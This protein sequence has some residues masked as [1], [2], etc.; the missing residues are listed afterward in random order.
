MGN[1]GQAP[2]H[3]ASLWWPDDHVWCVAS[4]VDLSWT[5]VGGPDA[6]VKAL[7]SDPKLEVLE[8]TPD[9]PVARIGSDAWIERWVRDAVDA[10]LHEEHAGISTPV[11]TVMAW[12][13]QPHSRKRAWLRT[14]RLSAW[15]H[16][17]SSSEVIN[18][19]DDASMRRLSFAVRWAI[20]ELVGD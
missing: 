6:L 18:L 13:E 9:V 10:L 11:G 4:D 16:R 8:I 5:F 2:R 19:S 3:S 17:G 7:V 15:G 12:F 20:V 1:P 14:N